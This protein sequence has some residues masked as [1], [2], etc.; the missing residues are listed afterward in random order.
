MTNKE[1]KMNTFNVS[2]SIKLNAVFCALLLCGVAGAQNIEL[3]QLNS[4][5]PYANKLSLAPLSPLLILSERVGDVGKEAISI[6][7]PKI[8]DVNEF[9]KYKYGI[10]Y[11]DVDSIQDSN[12]RMVFDTVRATLG[13]GGSVVI[14]TSDFNFEKMHLIVK[15]E[16]PMIDPSTI[17]DVAVL[18]RPEAGTIKAMRI[19]PSELAMYAGAK[20]QDTTAGQARLVLE[21]QA[22]S[23]A[24]IHF[25]ATLALDYAIKA[26]DKNPLPVGLYKLVY[27]GGYVDVWQE[28]DAS[29]SSVPCYVAWRGTDML[30]GS[31]LWADASSQFNFKKQVPIQEDVVLKA[32]SGFVNRFDAYK[33]AV[34]NKLTASGCTL[35]YTT[36]HS[37]GAAVSQVHATN[38]AYDSGF[39]HK[40]TK[41]YGWNSPNVFDTDARDKI[42]SR[43]ANLD[44]QTLIANRRNDAIVNS[45]PT[46]LK[47]LG[48]PKSTG[49]GEVD[50]VGESQSFNPLGNHSAAFW[51]ADID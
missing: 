20:F 43:L 21:K 16:F 10:V 42:R 37:L 41:V 12:Y 25:T 40:L 23:K 7:T 9:S 11:V 17:E 8:S 31:D 13:K 15:S 44:V 6:G 27:N 19:D 5:A 32:A 47:R 2:K 50:Y 28:N 29:T 34:N 22:H 51:Y 46:G 14:E 3:D 45:V 36:G 30:N 18:L 33:V 26:Y 24:L 35:I 49:I 1:L 48:N 39:K 4:H 38:L